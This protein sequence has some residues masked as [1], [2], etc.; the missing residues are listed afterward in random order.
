MGA[1]VLATQG[2][3]ASAATILTMLNWNILFPAHKGLRQYH[4]LHMPWPVSVPDISDLWSYFNG[5]DIDLNT[6]GAN[7]FEWDT[8]IS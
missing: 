6:G 8:C 7:Q 4:A 2:A 5:V 1:E 3:R